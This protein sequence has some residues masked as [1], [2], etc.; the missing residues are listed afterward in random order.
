MQSSP[1]TRQLDIFMLWR[2][3]TRAR[4]TTS[5]LKVHSQL[6][7]AMGASYE[8]LILTWVGVEK[9]GSMALARSSDG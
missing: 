7:S 6:T 2:S 9:L 1:C 5:G 3:C 8:M 4:Y